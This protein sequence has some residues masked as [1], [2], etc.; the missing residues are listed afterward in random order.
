MLCLLLLL[1]LLWLGLWRHYCLCWHIHYLLPIQRKFLLNRLFL[2][3]LLPLHLLRSFLLLHILRLVLLL[4]R[5]LIRYDLAT[6]N[7]KPHIVGT[8][9]RCALVQMKAHV[10]SSIMC[11]VE[12]SF[13]LL[14]MQSAVGWQMCEDGKI[15]NL[16]FEFFL[17]E[18][19]ISEDIHMV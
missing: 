18:E 15:V 8:E 4:W 19:S 12:S 2:F 16:S 17:L 10:L 3:L 1:L 11:E 9:S 13:D 14:R 5:S 6:F 7:S